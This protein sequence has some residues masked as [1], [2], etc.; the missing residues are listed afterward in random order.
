[1]QIISRGTSPPRIIPAMA[2][3]PLATLT[4]ILFKEI[5]YNGK[6]TDTEARFAV[7]LDVESLATNEI[8]GPLFE[9]DLAVIAPEI[10]EGL[11]I[12]SAGKQ[13]RL[14]V[15]RPGSFRLRFEVVAKITRSEPWN[16]IN[17]IGPPAAIAHVTASAGAG[18]E[19]NQL[20]GV[21]GF[22][23]SERNVHLRWQSK[24]A[25]VARKS[26]VT[27]DTTA[28]A[29]V[30]PTVIKYTTQ[31][32]YEILQAGITKLAIALP[33]SH[34]VTRVEGGQIR[35][36][37]IEE[38]RLS[39][40]FTKPAEKGYTLVLHTE[41]TI[42]GTAATLP[43]EV[44]QPLDIERESGAFNIS[45]DDMMVAVEALAG[46]RQVNAPKDTV[47]AFRFYGRPFEL[48]ARVRRIEPVV[49]V[50]DR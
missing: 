43:L 3:L 29:L 40:E 8:S 33:A 16:Q 39:I 15:T 28:S 14:I 9:G 24:T 35:D 37:Q 5:R 13:Y 31:F 20:S 4:N 6:V 26:L 45:A 49:K 22:L 7:T 32:R 10:P 17:F 27:V 34:A 42:E 12:V 48:N 50:A 25:E 47:A 2:A 30:T 18:I 38:E 23:G 19:M 36:W 21:D 41:Q 11:R 44:P 1:M 46:L